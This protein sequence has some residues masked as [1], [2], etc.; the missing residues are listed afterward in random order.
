M[1]RMF[2]AGVG[3]V[4][5]LYALHVG[6]RLRSNPA[7][8]PVCDISKSVSCTKSFSSSYGYLFGMPN[9][10]LGL[11]YY[12]IVVSFEG[13]LIDYLILLGLLFSVFLAYISY[14]RLKNFCIVCSAIYVINILLVYFST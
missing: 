13:V 1:S 5:S 6:L 11:L 10:V 7:Y 2:L 12:G 9:A 8:R 3:F 14:F 4:L